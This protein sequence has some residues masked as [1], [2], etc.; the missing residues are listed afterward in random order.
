MNI[1]LIGMPASGKT[2]VGKPL[3]AR[4]GYTFIDPD[5]VM[6]SE[7][8]K[9]LQGVLEELGDEA[10]LKKEWD[11]TRIA[12]RGRDRCVI[13]TGGSIVLT[14]E[15]MDYLADIA[16]IVYIKVPLDILEDRMGSTPRGTVGADS[17]SLSQIYAERTP[18]YEQWANVV[19][20]SEDNQ[21]NV[22][23]KVLAVLPALT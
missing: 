3:A 14:E 8:G 7:L 20:E 23:E 15:A 1:A 12:T 2:F 21:E 6:E 18:L 9:P 22:L 5:K 4:L 16:F 10:F 19:I 11:T 13:S 17:K